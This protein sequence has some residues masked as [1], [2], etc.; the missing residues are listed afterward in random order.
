MTWRLEDSKQNTSSVSS[1]GYQGQPKQDSEYNQNA[2]QCLALKKSIKWKV[3]QYTMLKDEKYSEAFIRNL[4]V[5]ATTHGCDKILEGDYMPGYDDDSQELF[6]Q[7]QY[8]MYNVFNKLLQSD[9]SKTI[10]KNMHQLWMH[11][12]YGRIL[13]LTCPHHPMD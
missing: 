3:S 1:T 6:K 10:V 2:H 5:T 11:N 12:Q 7:K 8:F 9:M 4:V 13:T